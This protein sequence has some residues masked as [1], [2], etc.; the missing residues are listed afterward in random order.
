MPKF[1]L[2]TLLNYL[3]NKNIESQK[4]ARKMVADLFYFLSLEEFVIERSYM[5]H[6]Y[7]HA[8]FQ[9]NLYNNTLLMYTV[10]L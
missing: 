7:K 9:L 6:L 10:S 5:A 1:R 3:E 2:P 4:T 8:H